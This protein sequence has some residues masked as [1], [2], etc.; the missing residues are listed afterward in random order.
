[1]SE[2]TPSASVTEAARNVVL[3]FHDWPA[4][5]STFADGER[6]NALN[7]LA[8]ALA[9]APRDAGRE[10]D[11]LIDLAWKQA[12]SLRRFIGRARNTVDRTT[13]SLCAT[14]ERIHA[15]R[16]GATP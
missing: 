14:V 13:I 6:R 11:E 1:M 5:T 9:A 16:R 7:A 4:F 10:E 12:Q 2:T 15:A 8:D 3:A